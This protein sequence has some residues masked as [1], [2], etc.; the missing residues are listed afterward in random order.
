MYCRCPGDWDENIGRLDPDPS[1]DDLGFLEYYEVPGDALDV[2][3]DQ[4]SS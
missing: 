3:Q 2:S 1:D 4:G